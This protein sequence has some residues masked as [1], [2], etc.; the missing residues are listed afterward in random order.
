M[1]TIAAWAIKAA[2]VAGGAV[3]F[4]GVGY[5]VRRMCEEAERSIRKSSK[6]E[7]LPD[8]YHIQAD[9]DGKRFIRADPQL[10]KSVNELAGISKATFLARLAK[11]EADREIAADGVQRARSKLRLN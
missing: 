11:E 7:P 6:P 4:A 10:L 1:N 2:A 8:W 3:I 5:G 9:A